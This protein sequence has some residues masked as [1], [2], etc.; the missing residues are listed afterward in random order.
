[1]KMTKYYFKCPDCRKTLTFPV[2]EGRGKGGFFDMH[3]SSAVQC[4]WAGR[5]KASDAFDI[6]TVNVKPRLKTSR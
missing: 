5:F 4:G 2:P 1:M 6:K 3:C